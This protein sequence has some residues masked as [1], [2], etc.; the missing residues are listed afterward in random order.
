MVL[1]AWKHF[2]TC[3]KTSHISQ[4]KEREKKEIIS[5]NRADVRTN[6]NNYRPGKS[7]VGRTN[8]LFSIYLPIKA[9]GTDLSDEALSSRKVQRTIFFCVLP[10]KSSLIRRARNVS[11]KGNFNRRITIKVHVNKSFIKQT[12]YPKIKCRTKHKF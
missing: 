11:V 12:F 10:K 4:T 3:N 1:S 8:Q 5:K 6:N 2:Q 9:I 7:D